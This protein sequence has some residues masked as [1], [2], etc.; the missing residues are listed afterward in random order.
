MN[1]TEYEALVG[2]S[3]SLKEMKQE[4]DRIIN[5][6]NWS[7]S[8]ALHASFISSALFRAKMQLDDL[9]TMIEE[10]SQ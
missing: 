9:I 1:S 5:G 7:N 10:E 3:K 8:I 4:L 6:S 2:L